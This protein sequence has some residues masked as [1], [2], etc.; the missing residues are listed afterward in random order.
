MICGK[1]QSDEAKRN[2]L[3]VQFDVSGL[4]G[5]DCGRGP[6]GQREEPVQREM[7]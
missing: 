3:E 2:S 4:S 5:N 7:Q 1:E 6:G